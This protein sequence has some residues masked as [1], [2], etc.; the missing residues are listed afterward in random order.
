MIGFIHRIEVGSTFN[1]GTRWVQIS[2]GACVGIRIV[3]QGAYLD[4][5]DVIFEMEGAFP[6]GANTNK[7]TA[8]IRLTINVIPSTRNTVGIG[9]LVVGKWAA[10]KR[11][12]AKV[13]GFCKP[14]IARVFVAIAV[15]I[16]T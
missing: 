11:V 10:Y 3:S 7:V 12:I 4:A 15:A 5:V 6:V 2:I 16:N 1:K 9:G 14:R 13:Q 8:P